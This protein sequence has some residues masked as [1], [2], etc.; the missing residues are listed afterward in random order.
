MYLLL[1]NLRHAPAHLDGWVGLG[2]FVAL[3]SGDAAGWT[4]LTLVPKPHPS[5][6]R[7]LDDFYVGA[8][9][10]CW[11]RR[12]M[13]HNCGDT[14]FGNIPKKTQHSHCEP[15][16]VCGASLKSV[17]QHSN[18]RPTVLKCLLMTSSAGSHGTLRLRELASYLGWVGSGTN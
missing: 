14:V 7:L 13:W 8:P 18:R 9:C 6:L 1:C 16:P 12:T 15:L 2:A 10:L 11:G 3:L 4:S 17:C 5:L